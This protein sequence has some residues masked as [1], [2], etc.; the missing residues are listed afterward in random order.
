LGF[1]PRLP[2]HLYMKAEELAL[3]Q[4][5]DDTRAALRRWNARPWPVLRSWALG[6]LGVALALLCATWLVAVLST[7][8]VSGYSFPGLTEPASSG[9]FGFL[10][11][12]NGLVLALHS[13]AC[14]AGFMAGFSLPQLAG[15]YTGLKR[16]VHEQAGPL[17]I[18]FV[19]CAT[20]FS[21]CTQAYALGRAAADLA[22]MEHMSPALLLLALSPHAV[23]ELFALFLP[24]AAWTLASRRGAWNELLAATFVTTALAIPLLL[25]AAAIEVWVSPHVVLALRG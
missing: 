23:P 19:V 7:P 17:A 6:S 1:R 24:L 13:L 22:L 8:D 3:V 15:G 20:A 9:D 2:I 5:W 10:L 12:R 25:L 21:L 14:V 18:G 11:Y 16:R 4:G